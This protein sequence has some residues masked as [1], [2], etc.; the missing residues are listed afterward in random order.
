MYFTHYSCVVI[1]LCNTGLYNSAFSAYLFRKLV[2]L[3]FCA[4]CVHFFFV[5]F[6][7]I[8]GN[9]QNICTLLIQYVSD[10]FV[11]TC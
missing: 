3:P 5:E 7:V 11:L 8:F 10:V 2:L 9:F 1:I 6:D 4:F